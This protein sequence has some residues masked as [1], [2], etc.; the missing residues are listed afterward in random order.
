MVVKP[1]GLPTAGAEP[2]K[3]SLH[4]RLQQGPPI[5]PYVGIV[6]RLDAAVSGVIVV[7]M[8]RVAAASLNRQFRDRS[9][10]KSYLAIVGGRF[11][12]PLEAWVAWQDIIY[13]GVGKKAS[14]LGKPTQ[15]AVG[16]GDLTAKEGQL[17][18]SRA[19]VVRRAGEASLVELEPDTGR[20]HQLRAQLAG[21]GCPIAGDRLYGSRLV[22]PRTWRGGIALHA[23]RLELKHPVSGESLAFEAAPPDCWWHRFPALQGSG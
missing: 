15:S 22:V 9:V 5:A 4:A 2:G 18:C 21:R 8:S 20:R 16:L 11:P 1:A 12:A 3:Q 19:R 14:S 6:S 13:R 23:N 7:A 17:A 10:R